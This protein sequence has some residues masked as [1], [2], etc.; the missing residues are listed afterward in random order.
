MSSVS[1]RFG[2]IRQRWR[3]LRRAI[4]LFRER[5]AFGFRNIDDVAGFD[6]ARDLPQVRRS[7]F[8]AR[9]FKVVDGRECPAARFRVRFRCGVERMLV[10]GALSNDLQH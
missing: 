2:H 6:I 4:I 10:E 1:T 3:G 5:D 9:L 8:G 7:V